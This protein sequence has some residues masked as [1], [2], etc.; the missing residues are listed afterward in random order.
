MFSAAER[1][2]AA[3][4]SATLSALGAARDAMTEQI[5]H[6]TYGSPIVQ[7]LVGLDPKDIENERR[8]GR[9][10]LREQA[11]AKRRADLETRWEQGGPADAALRSI[12]YVRRA[13]GVVDERGFAML[14]KLHD[15]QPPGRPRSMAQLKQA[16]REQSLLLRLDQD[17]AVE[18]LPKLLPPDPEDRARTFRAVQ[19]IVTASGELSDEGKRRLQHVEQL[20]NIRRART[21]KEGAD[22]R[23]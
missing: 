12:I 6:L 13:E 23:P 20:F 19:R 22:V 2:M 14:K 1:T 15:A 3:T 7:A 4:V 17:R 9:D 16:L 21:P 11:S 10:T 5:F 18:A 8:P